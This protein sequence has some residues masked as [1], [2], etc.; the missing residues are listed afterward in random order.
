MNLCLMIYLRLVAVPERVLHQGEGMHCAAIR[1]EV[2]GHV[3]GTQLAL[4]EV[5]KLSAMRIPN[6]HVPPRFHDH[7]ISRQRYEPLLLEQ[8]GHAL[9]SHMCIRPAQ[10]SNATSNCMN[11]CRARCRTQRIAGSKVRTAAGV[12]EAGMH[13]EGGAHVLSHAGVVCALVHLD[14]ERVPGL[15][16]CAGGGQRARMESAHSCS[17]KV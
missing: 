4:Q 12:G 15:G 10:V 17:G 5:R 2:P 13:R 11:F 3:G 1:I 9:L 16:L 6:S 7:I 8:A 14:N